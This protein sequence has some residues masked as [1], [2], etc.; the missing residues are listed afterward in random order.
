MR[1]SR[2]SQGRFRGGINHISRMKNAIDIA[3]EKCKVPKFNNKKI[4]KE[5][6]GEKSE[7]PT[8]RRT[9]E[10]EGVALNP[11]RYQAN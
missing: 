8:G 5:I 10:N 1:T 11:W 4:K 9:E 2:R 6:A 7:N 3:M